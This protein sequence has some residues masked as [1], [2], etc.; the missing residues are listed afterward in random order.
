M[1]DQVGCQS[2]RS[3]T[4]ARKFPPLVTLRALVLP[5]AL[6]MSLDLIFVACV[7]VLFL[8]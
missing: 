4:G 3:E 7:S 6:S 5:D 8:P 1:K 2:M